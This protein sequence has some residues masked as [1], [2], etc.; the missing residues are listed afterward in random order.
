[1][2]TLTLTEFQWAAWAVFFN[3]FGI[4]AAVEVLVLLDN[5]PLTL[6]QAMLKVKSEIKEE[7]KWK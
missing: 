7:I 3:K 6:G 1:M 5:S 2:T 4:D